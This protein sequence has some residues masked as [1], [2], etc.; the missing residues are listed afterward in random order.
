MI[1]FILCYTT[2]LK[3]KCNKPKSSFIQKKQEQCI[4]LLNVSSNHKLKMV[5]S[6]WILFMMKY[7]TGVKVHLKITSTKTLIPANSLEKLYKITILGTFVR[8]LRGTV[9]H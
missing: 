5:L 2:I 4:I 7:L 3:N 1:N 6:V 8:I 9:Y